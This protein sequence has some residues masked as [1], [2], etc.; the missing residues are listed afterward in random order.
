MSAREGRRRGIRAAASCSIPT[1]VIPTPP[2]AA[3][4]GFSNVCPKSVLTL[5][6]SVTGQGIVSE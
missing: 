1:P 5:M 6:P 2:A 3:Q 4:G